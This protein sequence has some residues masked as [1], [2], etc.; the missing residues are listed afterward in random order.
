MSA[1]PQVPPP[2]APDEPVLQVIDLHKRFGSL[3]DAVTL[4]LLLGE[5]WMRSRFGPVVSRPQTGGAPHMS[6]A[7]RWHLPGQ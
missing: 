4:L 2:P 1:A 7:S 3:D 6:D 5:Y